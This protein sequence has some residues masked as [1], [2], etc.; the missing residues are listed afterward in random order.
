LDEV[1][2][3]EIHAT[4]QN[5][6]FWRPFFRGKYTIMRAWGQLEE[7][8]ELLKKVEALCLELGARSS[9]AYCY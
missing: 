8:F 7:A 6:K 4:T 3:S 2:H 9:L 1:Q 5:N